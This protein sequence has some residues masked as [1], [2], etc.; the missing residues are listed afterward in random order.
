MHSDDVEQNAARPLAPQAGS[1][2]PPRQAYAP[3]VLTR[4]G[5][6]AELTKKVAKAGA[7]DGG[8]FPKWRTH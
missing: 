3:P 4:L 6:L 2:V 5:E 7:P 8:S 1:S